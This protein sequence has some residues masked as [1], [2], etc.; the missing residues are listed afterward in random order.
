MEVKTTAPDQHNLTITHK[1][2]RELK[3]VREDKKEKAS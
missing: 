2:R 3:G 1:R